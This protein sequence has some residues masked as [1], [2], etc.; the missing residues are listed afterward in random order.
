MRWRSLLFLPATLTASLALYCVSPSVAESPP[1]VVD[2]DVPVVFIHGIL[3]GVL[4]DSTGEPQYLTAGAALGFKKPDLRLPLTWEGDR[5]GRDGLVPA[6]ALM[7]VGLIRHVIDKPVYAPW[8]E[9]ASNVKK[10]PLYVFSYDWR[11]ANSES[12]E[13]FEKFLERTSARHSKR[14]VHIVAH[15]MGGLIALSVWIRRPDLIDRVIF[16]GVP[17]RGGIGYLDNMFLGTPIA[18][19][20]AMLSPEVIFSHPAVY[21]FY[22][23]A[24]PFENKILA[25]DETGKPLAIDYYNPDVWRTHGFGPFAPQNKSWGGEG[26]LPFLTA[27]LG[28]ARAFR[29]TLQP[30]IKI[31]YRKALVVMSKDHPTLD[32]IRRIPP[33]QG[34]SVPRWDFDIVPRGPGDGSVLY[35]DALPPE[36]IEHDVVLS[37]FG[38]SELLN[39]SAAQRKIEEFLRQE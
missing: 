33:G 30:D 14:K 27:A 25:E 3:G 34:E 20:P 16:A 8:I 36:P 35:R 2:G 31:A 1:P 6:G 9:F 7:R 13:L 37:G 17:F 12:A 4:A 22:P 28:R 24:Q 19:N 23:D 39:D 11:R 5:Q 29:R 26:R 15:S 32:R 18:A 21:S 10:R 38:H